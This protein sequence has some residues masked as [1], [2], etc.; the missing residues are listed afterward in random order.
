MLLK[1]WMD[2]GASMFIMATTIVRE[3]GITHLVIGSETYKTVS[4]V[5]T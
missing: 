4:K 3:L 1:D 5:I 2:T